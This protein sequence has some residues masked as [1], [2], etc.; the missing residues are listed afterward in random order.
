[1]AAQAERRGT[2]E[3][4]RVDPTKVHRARRGSGGGFSA[5]G[6]NTICSNDL[7]LPTHASATASNAMILHAK[8]AVLWAP[9][10]QQLH[11]RHVGPGAGARGAGRCFWRG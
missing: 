9:Q 11:V 4:V 10:H 3:F 1:M 7:R 8:R 6:L 2:Q 5:G